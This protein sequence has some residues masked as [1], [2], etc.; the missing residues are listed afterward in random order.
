MK[1][2]IRRNKTGKIVTKVVNRNFILWVVVSFFVALQV[3]SA[4]QTSSLGA[5]LASIEEEE[6]NLLERNNSLKSEIVS[7]TSLTKIDKIS[8]D[9]NFV[10]PQTSLY[11][12]ADNFVAKAN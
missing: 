4:I 8:K 1:T 6:N 2:Y 7:S 10:K 11:I 9:L 12:N 5:L 3:F